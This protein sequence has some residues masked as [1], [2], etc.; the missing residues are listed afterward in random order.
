[1]RRV[2]LLLLFVLIPGPAG[3]LADGCPPSSCGT[4]SVAP[5]GSPVTLIRSGGQQGTAVGYD[6][7]LRVRAA[8]RSRVA[9]S[10]RT[11]GHS[12]RLASSRSRVGG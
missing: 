10:R 11:G 9:F 2:L 3:A 1:M 12:S 7:T 5:A 6:L 4:T 8:S